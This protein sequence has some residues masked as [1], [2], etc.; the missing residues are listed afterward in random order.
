MLQASGEENPARKEFDLSRGD[1]FDVFTDLD[2]LG[3]GRSKPYVDKKDFFQDLKNPPKKVLK[4]LV[5]EVVPTI[6]PIPK[7]F[8]T[9]EEPS[10]I[11]EA[12][13]KES[14]A[15]QS[16]QANLLYQSSSSCLHFTN[17]PFKED[18]FEKD[19]FSEVDFSKTSGVFT[20]VSNG[21]SDP[22][23]KFENFEKFADFETKFVMENEKDEKPA[24][25]RVSLPPEKLGEFIWQSKKYISKSVGLYCIAHHEPASLSFSDFIYHGMCDGMALN[26]NFISG[27]QVSLH[28]PD[29]LNSE[30]G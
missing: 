7:L 25:L 6:E 4:D 19:P 12:D 11:V 23:E 17:D 29:D 20:P 30:D 1:Q 16:V 5:T 22:F 8:S 10:K 13:G 15:Q 2:P 21:N 14:L 24:P 26:K 9:D 3:T 18:P 27:S 28:K